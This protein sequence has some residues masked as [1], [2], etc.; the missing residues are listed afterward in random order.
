MLAASCIVFFS[1]GGKE[2]TLQFKINQQNVKIVQFFEFNLDTDYAGNKTIEWSVERE[3]IASVNNGK[4]KASGVGTTKVFAKINDTIAETSV[5]VIPFDVSELQI[6]DLENVRIQKNEETV[7]QPKLLYSDNEISG[8]EFSYNVKDSSIAEIDPAGNLI[9]RK[10]GETTCVVTANFSGFSISRLICITIE[11]KAEIL[12]NANEI[13][14]CVEDDDINNVKSWFNLE[15]DVLDEKGAK[16]DSPNIAITND[17]DSIIEI[18]AEKKIVAKNAGNCLLTV[19]YSG[20]EDELTKQIPVC[21]LK[22]V[23]EL[24]SKIERAV[25]DE[26]RFFSIN[27]NAVTGS[28]ETVSAVKIIDDEGLKTSVEYLNEQVHLATVMAGDF[29]LE[30]E[31]KNHRYI[32][33]LNIEWKLNV[34]NSNL[35]RLKTIENESV[36]IIEDLDFTNKKWETFVNFKGKINGNNHTVFNLSIGEQSGLFAGFGGCVSDL[37]FKNV[38]MLGNC[39]VFGY[40]LLEEGAKI[41]NVVIDIAS[42]TD[43]GIVGG[44]VSS[45]TKGSISIKNSVISLMPTTNGTAGLVAGLSMINEDLNN[46]VFV[47]GAG[48]N[49]LNGEKS[50]SKISG[51]YEYYVDYI[52][53][54]KNISSDVKNL[55]NEIFIKEIG[56]SNITDLLTLSGSENVILTQDVDLKGINWN[57]TDNVN[58]TFSGVFDGNNYTIKNLTAKENRGLFKNLGENGKTVVIRNL[59]LENVICGTG[60]GGAA[61]IAKSIRPTNQKTIKIK[62]ENVAVSIKSIIN[63]YAPGGLFSQ[64]NGSNGKIELSLNNVFVNAVK[65]KDD[66]ATN[67]SFGLIAGYTKNSI[68]KME[69]VLLIG[70]NGRAIGDSS[71]NF[72]AQGQIMS[73]YIGTPIVISEFEEIYNDVE[74]RKQFNQFANDCL[75][76]VNSTFFMQVIEVNNANK[77]ILKD[78][79]IQGKY[80]KLTEDLDFSSENWNSPINF[81]G[82]LD[83]NGYSI[84]NFTAKTNGG[85]FKELGTASEVTVIKNVKFN[86]AECGGDGGAGILAKAVNPAKGTQN[87]VRIENVVIKVTKVKNAYSPSALIANL[88]GNSGKISLTLK[89]VLVYACDVDD[90]GVTTGTFGLLAGWAYSVDVTASNVITISATSEQR[91]NNGNNSPTCELDGLPKFDTV[92]KAKEYVNNPENGASEFLK[93]QVNAL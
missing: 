35:E 90:T 28:S 8:G 6:R 39:G 59:K 21:V 24:N 71:N 55:A 11:T 4:V 48:K 76:W 50:S 87:T 54:Y 19:K 18:T 20:F 3:D 49:S 22:S 81:Y 85:L 64:V 2:D 84:N 43:D 63:N 44:I 75:E 86:N 74:K 7:L 66:G 91:G 17:D 16:I 10:V 52:D 77:S 72:D 5:E 79:S 23:K 42:I 69:N 60:G 15:V 62:I 32:I 29:V 1:C 37:K 45:A 25:E 53:A 33:P 61:V 13:T 70:A 30:V 47:G 14:L 80:V 26:S 73:E 89:D 88:R 68:V 78:V 92:E 9:A 67:G 12:S 83:G 58:Y 57:N 34:G 31:T 46:V 40:E 82:V 93:Q 27:L 41:E 51:S 38:T 36:S 65:I 56:Q